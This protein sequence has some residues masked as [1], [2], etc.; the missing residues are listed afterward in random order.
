[1]FDHWLDNNAKQ[2]TSMS[3]TLSKELSTHLYSKEVNHSI[4]LSLGCLPRHTG[5]L[6]PRKALVLD[7]TPV[8]VGQSYICLRSCRWLICFQGHHRIRM[9]LE[10]NLFQ[11]FWS[12]KY[13]VM[14]FK[15]FFWQHLPWKSHLIKWRWFNTRFTMVPT[16]FNN[17]SVAKDTSQSLLLNGVRNWRTGTNSQSRLWLSL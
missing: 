7:H 12:I 16:H 3:A 6:I 14:H 4:E 2:C 13:H 17:Y 9:L 10:T 1:M 15:V 11:Q 5:W 8:S